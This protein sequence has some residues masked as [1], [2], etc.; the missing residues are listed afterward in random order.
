MDVPTGYAHPDYAASL[1]AFGEPLNLPRSGG[2]LLVRE[3]PGTPHRDAMGPYPLL[4]CR[5]WSGLADDLDELRNELVSVTAVLDPFGDFSPQLLE[6]AFDSADPFKLHYVA[7][8]S[9]PRAELVKKSHRAAVRRAERSVEVEVVARPE[10]RLEEW[11]TLFGVLEARH[12][13]EGVRA[14]T[15]EAFN[16]QLRVPGTV[17]FEARVEG[18]IVGLDWW[19]VQDDVA[20]GHLVAM[21]ETGY[22]HR[23]SY[24]TKWFLLDW[25]RNRVRWVNFGGGA[26][27]SAPD[28]G[29]TRFKAGW[30][31]GT[32]SSRLGKRILQPEIYER[33]T[34]ETGSPGSPWFP[35]YRS[36][37]G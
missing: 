37:M 6:R 22:R 31:S 36:G 20:Q 7:D 1:A 5:N 8:L 12:S 23:A 19:Y 14:F 15:P 35:A 30:S 26:G 2:S 27:L 10:E 18:E 13:I 29:L 21:S 33:L 3:I 11:V 25:F 4:C 9:L 32:R 34:A 24:A 28:D 17:L 16:L